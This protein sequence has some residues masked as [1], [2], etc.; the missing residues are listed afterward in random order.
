M[1]TYTPTLVPPLSATYGSTTTGT[2]A[3]VITPNAGGDSIQLIGTYVILR[4][5]TSGTGSTITFDS[6]VPSNQGTDVNVTATLGATATQKVIVDVDARFKQQS[7][8]IGY[9]NLTYTSVTGMTIE[10]EYIA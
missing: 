5:A 1:A 9:L 7:G 3:T 6:V 10:A 8:N 4:F 2:A